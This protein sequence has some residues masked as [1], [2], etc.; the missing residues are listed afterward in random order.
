[1]RTSERLGG[2][3]TSPGR[4][5]AVA[6]VESTVG[7]V[8]ERL[9]WLR[10]PEPVAEPFVPGE[11][12]LGRALFWPGLIG[13]LGSLLVLWGASQPT[14]PFTLDQQTLS[15]LGDPAIPF[16]VRLWFF[17]TGTGGPNELIGVVAVYAGMFL[18]IRAWMSLAR[19][20]RHHP[21]T[22]IRK[23]VPV[24][25]A[26]LLPLLVVA[27]L[28]SHDAF[29]YV[30]QGEE[31]THNMNPY[32]YPPSILG[33]G[34]NP[35][36]TLVDHW[37]AGVTSPYGPIFLAAAGGTVAFVHH[38]TSNPATIELLALIGFRLL[39]VFGV[40]LLGIY[41]PRLARSYGRDPAKAFVLVALNPLVLLHLVAG[42]HNDAIMMGLLVAGLALARER[43]PLLGVMLC[44]LAGLVKVPA[45][46]GVVYIGWDWAGIGVPWRARVAP[47]AKALA[48]SA[49]TM[50]AVTYAVGIG[51][52]WVGSLL[53]PGSVT[54][55]MDPAT[56]I[57]SLAGRIVSAVGLGDHTST[58]VGIAHGIGL[59][60]AAVVAIWLLLRSDGGISSLRAIGLTMLAV[61][62]LGPVIQPWYFVWGVVLLAPI[63]EGRLRAVLVVLSAV[64]SYLGLPG[65]VKLLDYIGGHPLALLVAVAVLLTVG[66]LSF[67]PRVHEVVKLRRA[68]VVAGLA[69]PRD[70]S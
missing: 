26:W 64:M 1:M 35:Y 30:A 45:L 65:G 42:E 29:S 67:G 12:R 69:V 11:T 70:G 33:V 63:A 20:T 6:G 4:K 14:S 32:I 60:A 21:G 54:S 18:M 55:W 62:V 38:L 22:P 9:R 41:T 52:G 27:P 36:A 15:T 10:T 51:W 34:G 7:R 19:L 16:G 28:F 2:H 39:A 57:G 47:T 58:I 49:V 56:G 66:L 59:A 23:F 37:W 43:H 31:M 8:V 40:V 48:A 3:T 53:T 68:R 13:A 61:V 17:G 44:T 25:I 50:V 5:S 46:I 24:F